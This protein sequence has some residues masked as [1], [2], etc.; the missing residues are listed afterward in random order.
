[1]SGDVFLSTRCAVVAGREVF[2]G[3][4]QDPEVFAPFATDH[5]AESLL[6]TPDRAYEHIT[7]KEW[8]CA[9]RYSYESYSN[10]DG[11]S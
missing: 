7:G 9:T 4:L 6:Y 3:A 5:G 10:T 11:A 8:D 1:M 2:A